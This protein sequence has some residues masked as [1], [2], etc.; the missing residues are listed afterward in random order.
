VIPE[1]G[2]FVKVMVMAVL[3]GGV[4][5]ESADEGCA[6]AVQVKA[7]GWDCNRQD[8]FGDGGEPGAALR[9]FACVR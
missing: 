2:A 1:A 4:R 9:P 3:L 7:M 8:V 6:R 5:T